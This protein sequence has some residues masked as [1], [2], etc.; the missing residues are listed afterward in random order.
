MVYELAVWHGAVVY[1]VLE[2]MSA[3]CRPSLFFLPS[4]LLVEALGVVWLRCWLSSLT[5]CK[6]QVQFG[7]CFNDSESKQLKEAGQTCRVHCLVSGQPARLPG[8]RQRGD[9]KKRQSAGRAL[10]LGGP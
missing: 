5:C 3:A 1:V 2:A 10:A 4:C 9:E 7:G 6:M 8:W